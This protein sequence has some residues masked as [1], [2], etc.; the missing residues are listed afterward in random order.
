MKSILHPKS[1]YKVMFVCE[2]G[3]LLG[4]LSGSE[5]STKAQL[6]RKWFLKLH[7]CSR[8]ILDR[9]REQKSCCCNV[10]S[11]EFSPSPSSVLTFILL[12]VL[13]SVSSLSPCSP[14]FIFFSLLSCILTLCRCHFPLACCIVIMS[15]SPNNAFGFKPFYFWCTKQ[16]H[17]QFTHSSEGFCKQ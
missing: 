16:Q 14:R 5:R 2:W 8:S 6:C 7:H 12:F 1:Q 13:R 17:L 10:S 3:V 4:K 9:T 11:F 15:L